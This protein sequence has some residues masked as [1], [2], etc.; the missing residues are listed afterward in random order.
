MRGSLSAQEVLNA[1]NTQID[2]YKTKLHNQ[3]SLSK[4]GSILASDSLEKLK[5]LVR[6]AVDDAIIK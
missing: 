4:G 2:L 5:M 3:R 1:K 6:K